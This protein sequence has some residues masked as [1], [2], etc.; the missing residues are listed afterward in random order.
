MATLPRIVFL[1]GYTLAI[2]SDAFVPIE[3]LGDL[4]VHDRTPPEQVVERAAGADIVLTNKAPLTADSLGRLD[5]LKFISVTATG[6]NVVDSAA[7]AARSVPVSNVPEYGTDTVAQHV[8]ALLLELCNRVGLH[9]ESVHRGDWVRSPDWCYTLAPLVE[10]RGKRIGIVGFGRIGRKVGEIA[11]ALGMEVIASRGR[12]QPPQVP[13]PVTQ[14]SLDDL[15]AQSDVVT[16]H[17]PLTEQTEGM[18]NGQRLRTMK[19]AAMLI[20]CAR[21]GLVVEQ[22]LAD[23][24]NAGVIAGAA[25]DVVSAEPIR[26]ENP[27]LSARN[28]ILTPHIAWATTEAKRRLIDATAANIAAFLAGKPINVVNNAR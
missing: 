17:V 22:D 19:R 5:R 15:F 10:L 4:T 2:S 6:H 18:I 16:L 13:Y 9:D 3:R 21:G 11:A 28:C 25:V 20:N 24:L 12:S 27:L 8:I 14:A 26:P 23:A 1:D 7:A